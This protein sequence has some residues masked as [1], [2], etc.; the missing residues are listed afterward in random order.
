MAEG[1]AELPRW[2]GVTE[3]MTVATNVVLAGL[4]FVLA[5]RLASRSAAVGSAAGAWLAAGLSATGLAALVAAVAH[6]ADPVGAAALRE[7]FWRGALYTTGLIGAAS[8]TSVAFFAARGYARAAILAFAAIKLVVF[9]YRVARRPEFRVAAADYGG[10]LAVLLAGAAYEAYRSRAPGM[11]WLIAGVL[12]SLVAGIVQARRLALH[13]HFNHN[14]LYH[15][16][17]MAALYAF[18]RGG[19][20]LADR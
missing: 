19:A 13:R 6:G 20:Q 11:T 16:I 15:L 10:A 17:Q 12:V 18:Y 2:G 9:V 5:A 1:S 7:R 8:V 14:D 3:P 4:A